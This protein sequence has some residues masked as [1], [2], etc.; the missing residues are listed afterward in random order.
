MHFEVHCDGEGQ[1]HWR[2][3]DDAGTV[4]AMSPPDGYLYQH[5]CLQSLQAVKQAAANAWVED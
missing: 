4:Y 1:W 3:V 5:A 2:L